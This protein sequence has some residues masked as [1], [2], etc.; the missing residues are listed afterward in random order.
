[1][2]YKDKSKQAEF[3]RQW[4]AD[5]RRQYIEKFGGMCIRCL[6]SESLEF[7][8][9]NRE[10]KTSHR[11]WSWQPSRIEEELSKCDLLCHSCHM[12][13]TRAQIRSRPHVHGTEF[14]YTRRGCRCAPCSK[15]HSN[16][17]ANRRFKRSGTPL[18]SYAR[19]LPLAA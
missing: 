13:E 18:P 15:A 9:R 7:H 14:A 3:Q 5:R 4:M 16:F 2:P 17:L 19:Q 11:V 8:H 12:E 1:M 6:S 10:E